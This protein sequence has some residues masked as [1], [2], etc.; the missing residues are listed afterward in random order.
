MILDNIPKLIGVRIKELRAATNL[1][2]ESFAHKIGMARTYF[3]EVETGKRN[4]S[5]INLAKIINGLEVS[6]E[7]FFNSEL[8]V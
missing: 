8:F 5:I 1:S 2:Q 3:A 4:V 6:L 7:E